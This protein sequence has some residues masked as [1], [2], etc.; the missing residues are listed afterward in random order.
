[1][2]SN[3]KKNKRRMRKVQAQRKALEERFVSSGKGTPGVC[4]VPA[5]VPAQVPVSK[6]SECPIAVPIPLA[7]I[8]P[9]DVPAEVTPAEP[10]MVQAPVTDAIKDK[11]VKA[12]ED[13]RQT[14]V[15]PS[16]KELVLT[17]EGDSIAIPV[18][19]TSQVLGLDIHTHREWHR[20]G[21]EREAHII[22][23]I[24]SIDEPVSNPAESEVQFE[25]TT[26]VATEMHVVAQPVETVDTECEGEGELP[27]EDPVVDVPVP[28]EMVTTAET[29]AAVETVT[30]TVVTEVEPV[31]EAAVE[32]VGVVGEPDVEAEAITVENEPAEVHKVAEVTE[33]SVESTSDP[34]TEECVLTETVVADTTAAEEQIP[35]TATDA[36]EVQSET[37]SETIPAPE[38]LT[39]PVAKE[40]IQDLA[41]AGGL[42][43]DAINGC[44]GATEV[45]IEG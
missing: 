11:V 10:V 39:V 30:E 33:P 28:E 22:I 43:V 14:P 25:D 31:A 18:L 42:T 13:L 15:E 34:I 12:A 37:L 7:V 6:I 20:A 2:P 44:L 23:V 36:S 3:R 9:I 38:P 41:V 16:A 19:E 40:I 4:A 1:M 21:Q 24:S 35:E 8:A 17:E 27:A 29:V 45:A 32:V 26:P 5:P